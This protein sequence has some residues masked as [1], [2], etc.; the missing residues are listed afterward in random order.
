MRVL[1]NLL[2]VLMVVGIVGT[3]LQAQQTAKKKNVVLIIA[4]DLGLD[5]AAYGNNVIKTPN[6]DRLAKNG[7]VFTNAYATVA[8][9][10]ASRGSILTGMYTHQNG[11]FGHAHNPH[12]QHTFSRLEGLPVLL[13]RAGYYTG[14][15]GKFHVQPDSVYPFQALLT[16]KTKGNRGPEEMAKLASQFFADAKGRPFFLVYASSDPHRSAKRFGNENFTNDPNEVKYDPKDVIVPYFLPD[17]PEV[18]QELAEYYQSASR[19]DRSVGLLMA[20]LREAG[21]GDDTMVI[22]ISDN[23][24]PFPGAKTNLY[25]SGVHL[26]LI[27]SAPGHSRGS[28]NNAMVSYVDLFPTIVDYTGAKLP[29]Y[30]LPGRS[31]LPILDKTNPKGWDEVYGSHQFHEITMYYP[32]RFVETR[33][34]KL[35]VN[36]AHKLDYPFASDLWASPSWQGIRKRGDKM[37]GKRSVDAYLHRP[38]LE[39]YDLTKDPNELN[40]VANDPN[41]ADVL[42]SMREKLVRWQR[43]TNDPWTILYDQK[44]V[45]LSKGK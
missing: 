40:N 8:S 29:K 1:G 4:D 37:M 18:R 39:L 2:V 24:I 34:H 11:Q 10:S 3:P 22:F 26:P 14:L 30:R 5:T 19:F 32:M 13:N 25:R 36:L 42:Q 38:L 27:I 41:Y 6:L 23:G 21:H 44:E 7:I 12:G 20:A 35:I 9:C 43:Q 33:K 45:E 17:R 16:K 15:I 28:R 31:L